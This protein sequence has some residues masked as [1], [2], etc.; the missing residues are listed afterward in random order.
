MDKPWFDAQTGT[1]LFDEYVAKRPSFQ[2]VMADAVVTEDE[3]AEQAARVIALLQ[4]LDGMLSAEAH[5]VAT[6][7]L[8]ELAVLY[9]L[10]RQHTL[11]TR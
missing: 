1:L 3:V 2:K 4:Q 10:E 6:D 7:T 8:C 11:S 9:A 5:A